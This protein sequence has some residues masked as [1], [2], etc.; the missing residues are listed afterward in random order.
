MIRALFSR[1]NGTVQGFR[2]AAFT[3]IELLVVIA[4]IAILAGL[5]LPALSKSTAKAQS[6]GCL[7][8]L[9]RR[10][11]VIGGQV[12][13]ARQRVESQHAQRGYHR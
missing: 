10:E 1:G 9:R 4:I 11:W 5:L 13:L 3:L 12:R 2:E 7:N 6:I 8:N